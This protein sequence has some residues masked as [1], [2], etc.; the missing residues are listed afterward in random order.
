MNFLTRLYGQL[1]RFANFLQDYLLLVIRLYWGYSF[2]QAGW[3]KLQNP[4]RIISFFTNINIPFPEFTAQFVGWVEC[5]GGAFLFLGL[6]SR[7]A[8]LP[9]AITMIVAMF[10]AHTKELFGAF[11]NPAAFINEA[12]TQHLA[13]SLIIFCFGA[14]KISIEQFLGKF[15]SKK[16]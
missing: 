15:Y 9:L 5:V 16:K 6:L 3:G 1:T 11:Q 13:A 4:E 10:T 8:A 14:G 7:F 2:F 12:A